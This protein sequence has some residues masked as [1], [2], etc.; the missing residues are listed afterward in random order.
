M[1]NGQ[2][3][4]CPEHSGMVSEKD[5]LKVEIVWLKGVVERLQTRLPL[6]ATGAISGLTFLLGLSVGWIM[7]LHSIMNNPITKMAKSIFR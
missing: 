3:Q 7:H 4:F 1:G 6:W 2:H 5:N